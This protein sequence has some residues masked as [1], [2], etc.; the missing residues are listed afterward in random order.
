MEQQNNTEFSIIQETKKLLEKCGEV[1]VLYTTAEFAPFSNQQKPD[2]VFTP[3]DLEGKIFFIEFKL[4]RSNGFDKSY[5]NSILEHKKF[6]QEDGNLDYEVEYAFATNGKIDKE[7]QEFLI[8]NN[9]K[10]F[11]Q[12]G[13]ASDLCKSIVE[14][15]ETKLQ[16]I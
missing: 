11:P 1:E 15:S 3:Y 16:C 14:W 5:F 12:I 6:V 10:V 4:G 9:I 7:Y 8:K 2:L 13:N